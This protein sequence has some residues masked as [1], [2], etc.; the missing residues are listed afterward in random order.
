MIL[1]IM[2]FTVLMTVLVAAPGVIML[3]IFRPLPFVIIA[4]IKFILLA[5]VGDVLSNLERVSIPLIRS[6]LLTVLLD[7]LNPTSIHL[8]I[9]VISSGSLPGLHN[10][11]PLQS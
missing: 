1:I 8:C 3:R 6:R 5:S 10:K 4:I 9:Q 11:L 7:F 2:V